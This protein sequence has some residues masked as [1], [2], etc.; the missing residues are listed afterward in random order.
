MRGYYYDHRR[1]DDPY[2][3]Y[4][5]D[6][7]GFPGE[8]VYGDGCYVDE[9]YMDEVWKPVR[10]FPHYWVSNKGRVYSSLSETFVRGTP[11]VKSG[12]IDLSLHRS[13]HRYHKFLH[14]LVAEAFIPNPFN[15]PTVRHLNDNP[16]DNCVENLAWGTQLDN[17]RD[18]IKNGTFRYFT[19]EDYEKAMQKRR[20]P[21]IAIRFSDNRELYF[22]SQQEAS[23]VLNIHQSSI[24][25][26]IAGKRYGA[27]GYYFAKD[28]ESFDYSKYEEAKKRYSRKYQKIKAIDIHTKDEYVFNSLTEAAYELDM[29]VSSISMV[30]HGKMR[31]AK[32]WIFEYLEE[33]ECDE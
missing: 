1:Y 31:S 23:R 19:E 33:G 17:V 14:R 32:G 22:E 21:I 28:N 3:D 29:S 25:L 9:Y 27:D 12:H 15:Y 6:N 11:N 8:Y 30:L 4:D 20:M 7:D 24:Y 10:G 26:V 13:G 16:S 5:W 2:R 18:S